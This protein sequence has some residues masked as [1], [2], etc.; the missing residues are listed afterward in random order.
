M[1]A[2]SPRFR[3]HVLIVEDNPVNVLV[4]QTILVDLGLTVDVANDGDEALLHLSRRPYNLVFMDCQMP[5]KDGYT[6]T[7]EWRA[8]E[9]AHGMSRTPIVALTANAMPTDRQR[10]LDAGMD[11]H[12]SKPYRSSQ[13]VDVLENFLPMDAP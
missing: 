13:L 12:L 8:R 1:P 6:T 7:R 2:P 5:R 11:E 4:A 10:S 3:G 9:Q